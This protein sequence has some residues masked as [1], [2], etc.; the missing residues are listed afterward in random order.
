MKSTRIFIVDDHPVVYQGL[1]A[2]LNQDARFEVCGY[3]QDAS[4]AIKGI[5]ESLPDLAIVDISLQEG[6]N[7]LDLMKQLSSSHP[8]LKIIALSMHDESVYSERAIRA[9]AHGYVMKSELINTLV[10]AI[11]QVMHGEVYLSEKIASKLL[12]KIM[13]HGEKAAVDVTEQLTNR[14]FEVFSL[15]GD[16]YKTRDI[17]EKLYLSPKTVETYRMRI[18]EKLQLGDSSELSRYAVSWTR[19]HS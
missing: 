6:V 4:A 15:I 10:H 7:G 2:L 19:E 16:G 18:R 12:R 8:K 11:E 1:K 14:E 3:A 17:A 13:R 9:G 5:Q